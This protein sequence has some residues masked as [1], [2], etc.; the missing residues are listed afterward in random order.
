LQVRNAGSASVPKCQLLI[1]WPYETFSGQHVLYLLDEPVIVSITL[2]TL[3]I[4]ATITLIS[5]NIILIITP[6]TVNIIATITLISVD[7]NNNIYLQQCA[8]YKK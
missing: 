8:E 5:V 2:I 4:I 3:D 7:I 1:S 6:I